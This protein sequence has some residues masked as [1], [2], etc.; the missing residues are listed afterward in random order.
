MK[1]TGSV[2]PSSLKVSGKLLSPIGEQLNANIGDQSPE[3]DSLIFRQYGCVEAGRA[4]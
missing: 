1:L 2:F 4:Q 3:A